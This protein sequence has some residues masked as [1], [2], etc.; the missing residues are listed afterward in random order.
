MITNDEI[1]EYGLDYI[2]HYS[3]TWY[4]WGGG[5]PSGFDCSGLAGE[6]L[7]ACGKIPRNADMTAQEIWNK[8]SPLSSVPNPYRGCLV[9]YHAADD[10]N[11][12][13]HVEICLNE[14][15]SLGA[16]G[17]GS[18]TLTIEDAIAQNA[19]VKV[20]PIRSRGNIK[21]FVDPFLQSMGG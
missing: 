3:G 17:G 20:R 8:F 9:L 6:F 13:I 7:Q 12:V 19:F 2:L 18:K 14:F 16:S 1:K 21:G 10:V 5:G 11:R 15:Q 4:K